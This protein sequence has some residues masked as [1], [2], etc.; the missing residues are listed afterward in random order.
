MCSATDAPDHQRLLEAADRV[1]RAAYLWIRHGNAVRYPSQERDVRQDVVAGLI[2]GLCNALELDDRHALMS[3]YA[4]ALI[5]GDAADA[6][7]MAQSM[8]RRRDDDR[9]RS[10]YQ[11]GLTAANDLV[12][13]IGAPAASPLP[14]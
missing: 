9:Y 6:L 1:A 4:Y 3:A 5:D 14:N 10:A 12:D 13:L 11:R 2:F 7:I 8:V